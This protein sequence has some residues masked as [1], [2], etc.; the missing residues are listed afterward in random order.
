MRS[1]LFYSIQSLCENTAQIVSGSCVQPRCRL[2]SVNADIKSNKDYVSD[3]NLRFWWKMNAS[4]RWPRSIRIT[5]FH[6]SKTEPISL[7]SGDPLSISAVFATRLCIT[8]LDAMHGMNWHYMCRKGKS[9][10][11]I[12]SQRVINSDWATD[13]TSSSCKEDE[14]NVY[15]FCRC[16]HG[17]SMRGYVHSLV[18]PS[19][20]S[21]HLNILALSL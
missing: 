21:K 2:N 1:S 19:F 16:A 11:H 14:L 8:T 15:T 6:S 13:V 4:L 9:K 18:G 5:S 7:A 20:G 10:E 3:K 17:V 12:S